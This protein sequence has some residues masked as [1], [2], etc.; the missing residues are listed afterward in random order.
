VLLRFI[1]ANVG[2]YG[3]GVAAFKE[4]ER[5]PCWRDG[6]LAAIEAGSD[7]GIEVIATVVADN[8]FTG[9]VVLIAADVDRP[10]PSGALDVNLSGLLATGTKFGGIECQEVDGGVGR[11]GLARHWWL[12][13]DW[14]TR[15]QQ[16]SATTS[17]SNAPYRNA[18]T[19]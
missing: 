9:V 8:L 18:S 3:E 6:F 19:R 13:I 1:S 17:A 12:R 16:R 10:A 14:L 7:N 4:G 2:P 15:I 11:G 5:L